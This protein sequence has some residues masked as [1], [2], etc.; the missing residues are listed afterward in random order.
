MWVAVIHHIMN[1][2]TFIVDF[3]W[4]LRWDGLHNLCHQSVI[5]HQRDAN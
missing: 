4:I 3:I 5:Y 1:N 2:L